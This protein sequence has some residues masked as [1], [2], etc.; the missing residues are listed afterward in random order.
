MNWR[1]WARAGSAFGRNLRHPQF[2]RQVA[3][4]SLAADGAPPPAVSTEPPLVEF[5]DAYPE[6]AGTTVSM[7]EVTY[8]VWNMDP[9]ERFCVA[10]IAGLHGPKRIF[11]FG[12]FDGATTLLLARAVP[13]AEVFTLDLPPETFVAPEAFG[14]PRSP[15]NF[16]S[17]HDEVGHEFLGTQQSDRI[18][19]L[20]GDSRTF[21]YSD[22]VGRMD[23]VLVDAGHGYEEASADTENALRLAGPSGVVIWDDYIP[24]WPGVIQAVNEAAARHDFRVIRLRGTGLAIRDPSR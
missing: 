5:L 14:Y 17:P 3:K 1:Y 2:V 10:A 7:G 24:M 22:Y 16:E 12:T 15:E 8:K 11:E 19:Q 9:M 20:F 13:S 4:V 21:D 6:A 23:L 18:T